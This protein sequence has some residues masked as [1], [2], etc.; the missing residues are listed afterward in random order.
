[1]VKLSREN[2]GGSFTKNCLYLLNFH[3]QGGQFL[4]FA[5]TSPREKQTL[6]AALSMLGG[7]GA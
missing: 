7:F 6:G 5:K 2:L 3:K 1:M 4:S